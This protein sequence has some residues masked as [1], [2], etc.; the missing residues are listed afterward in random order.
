MDVPKTEALRARHFR[1]SRSIMALVLREMST[2]YGKS[3]GGY[4]WAIL[5]P[6][7]AIAVL[8]MA[9]QFVFKT[10]ALGTNFPFYFATGYLP[11]MLCM[12]IMGNTAKSIR[13]SKAL[14]AYP[15]V[16]WADAIFAR[17]ILATLTDLLTIAIVMTAIVIIYDIDLWIEAGPLVLCLGM[18]LSLGLGVGS[19]NCYLFITYPAWEQIWTIATRPLLL[20]SGVMFLFD[21]LPDRA[22]AI[23]VWNPFTH[24]TGASRK[25]FYTIY[26]A[27]YLNPVFVFAVALAC[28]AWGFM[29]LY[30]H[31]KALMN[32]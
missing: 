30:R 1:T 16:T 26:D 32:V 31:H 21:N 20:I 2:T 10:P 27:Y 29:L 22:R 3:P 15:G 8:S 23:L 17:M 9:F 4:L 19:L 12:K 13:F 7:A 28:W 5:E 6:V 14:L 25:G 24:I 18:V 11:Y